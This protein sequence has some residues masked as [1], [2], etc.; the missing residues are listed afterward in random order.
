[1]DGQ[2]S[3]DKVYSLLGLARDG[4][5]IPINFGSSSLQLLWKVLQ[6]EGWSRKGELQLLAESLGIPELVPNTLRHEEPPTSLM[7][8]TPSWV[9][10]KFVV[11][12]RI[13]SCNIPFSHIESNVQK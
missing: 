3:L 9:V 11:T 1:M 2:N 7:K 10:E 6:Q 8:T 5:R 4:A 13:S 12:H